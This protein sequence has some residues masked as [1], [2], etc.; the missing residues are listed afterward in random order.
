MLCPEYRFDN[1]ATFC[2]E[3]GAKLDVT[4]PSC[5]AAV[6]AGRKFCGSCGKPLTDQLASAAGF[7]FPETY[8]PK[9]L[10]DRILN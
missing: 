6:A 9:H 7:S 3:C 1:R 10:A 4:C 8:T 5:G 2:E